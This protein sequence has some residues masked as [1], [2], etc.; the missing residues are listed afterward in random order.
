[1]KYTSIDESAD[2]ALNGNVKNARKIIYIEKRRT[3]KRQND[4]FAR[5][6]SLLSFSLNKLAMFKPTLTNSR[7]RR[8][9]GKKHIEPQIS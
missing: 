9:R 2:N 8:S 5:A 6:L 3:E 4:D 1:M 7:K